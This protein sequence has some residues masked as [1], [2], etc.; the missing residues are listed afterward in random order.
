VDPVAPVNAAD[1]D[2]LQPLHCQGFS[3]VY[4]PKREGAVQF[5]E[6]LA[7]VAAVDPEMRVRFTSPHPKDF[8]DDVLQVRIR[9]CRDS[10]FVYFGCT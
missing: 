8:S 1:L 3:S 4:V 9:S 2:K 5:A 7:R 6:L 10:L